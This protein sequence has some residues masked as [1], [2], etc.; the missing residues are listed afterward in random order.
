[1]GHSTVSLIGLKRIDLLR[2]LRALVS[3]SG[4]QGSGFE[5]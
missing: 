2:V 4:F 3:L 1:M 5:I